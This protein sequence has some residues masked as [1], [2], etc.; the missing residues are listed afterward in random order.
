MG[1][2]SLW[3]LIKEDFSI[4]IKDDPAYGSKIELFFNY[5]GLWAIV[6]YRISNAIYKKNMKVVARI[7]S[8]ISR[9]LTAVDIHPEATIG[10]RVFIDHGTGV[11]IGQTAIIED[12]VT[13]YQQVTLG[14]VS[15]SRGKRHPTIKSNVVIGTGAKVLGD[16]TIGENS[17]IGSNSVVITDVPENSTAVGVPAKIVERKNPNAK[18]DHNILP[19][20]SRNM[21]EYL[22]KRVAVLEHA[23]KE[24]DGIDLSQEDKELENIYKKFIDAMKE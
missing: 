8:G 24:Y 19:D 2:L 11:V 13:I 21:F 9:L 5:P 14:G 4:P 10:R 16:I 3:R 15:L 1:D 20:V 7:V 18:L 23:I 12:D 6:F 17:K 22:L